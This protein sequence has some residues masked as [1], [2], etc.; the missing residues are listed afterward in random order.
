MSKF[1]TEAR[2]GLVILTAFLIFIW[3]TMKITHVGEGRGYNINAVFDNASGLENNA[4]VRMVGVSVGRVKAIFIKDRKALVTM[5]IN[6]DVRVDKDASFTIRSQG[7]LGDKYIEIQP[8]SSD[9][10]YSPGE[11]TRTTRVPVDMENLLQSLSAAGDSLTKILGSLEKVVAS[12]D[13]ERSLANILENTRKL[14]ENLD[15]LVSENREDIRLVIKNIREASESLKGDLPRLAT[16]LERAS[17][18]VTGLIDDNRE[19]FKETVDRL[20]RNTEILEETLESIRVV[21]RRIE[22][23]EGTVGKLINDDEAYN[24]LNDTLSGLNKVIRRTESIK[25]NVDLHGHYLTEA[26]GTKGYL[27]LDIIPT[28]DKFYR[29]ELIDDPEGL[30]QFETSTT[31]STA[32]TTTTTT[33]IQEEIF[34]DKFKF[35]V[36][37]QT[38][39]RHD[40]QDR[41]YRILL[42]CGCRQ[43]P[44]ERGSQAVSRCLGPGPDAEP[45]APSDP[46]V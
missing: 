46:F 36:T 12:E 19:S 18:Q 9:R 8:G 5:S 11:T 16:K 3:G 29:F 26:D 1:S 23:G 38:L 44:D 10:N 34:K 37:R 27:T 14:S 2:L 28:P 24:N 31:T 25:L 7:I 13:G 4:P 39:L 32:G 45:K 6:E 41:V 30:R 21:S 43:V 35:S 20:R 40:F 22:E 15:I 17:E 42:R 33:T